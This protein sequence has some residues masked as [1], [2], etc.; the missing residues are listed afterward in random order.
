LFA[1]HTPAFFQADGPKECKEMRIRKKWKILAVAALVL[2]IS[3][4]FYVKTHPLVFNESFWEHAHCMKI[5]TMTLLNYAAH[6]NGQ[7]P[8]HPG[9][10]GDALLLLD[11]ETYHT[12]TGPG[13]DPSTF[14]EAKIKGV[15]LPEEKCGRVYIQ[16]LASKMNPDIVILFDKIPTPGGDHA[17]FPYRLWAP[18]RREVGYIDG[19]T[20]AIDETAWAQFSLDQVELLVQN[21]IPKNQARRLWGLEVVEK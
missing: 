17:H 14:H 6:H 20:G 4:Y 5:A 12:L 16:G 15:H 10:Y 13:F 9:G 19:H 18:L 2:A 1:L 7:F 11:E 3:T 21:G 8:V